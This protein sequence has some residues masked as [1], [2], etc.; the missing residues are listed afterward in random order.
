MTTTSHDPKSAGAMIGSFVESAKVAVARSGSADLSHADEGEL[1]QQSHQDALARASIQL[2]SDPAL[3][4]NAACEKTFRS[5][6]GLLLTREV[7][8][9]LLVLAAFCCCPHAH[10]LSF[11]LLGRAALESSAA[12]KLLAK[13]AAQQRS[14]TSKQQQATSHSLA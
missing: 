3:R 9:F 7:C 10:S 11:C 1:R 8:L 12:Q 4:A 6:A 2:A 14:L 13:Q 5:A